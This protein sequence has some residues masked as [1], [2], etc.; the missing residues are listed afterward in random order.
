MENKYD[1]A[2]HTF[3][4]YQNFLVSIDNEVTSLIVAALFCIFN[5]L[6][7]AER[8]KMAKLTADHNWDLTYLDFVALEER[9]FT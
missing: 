8:R 2:R 4:R 9:F 5:D 6:L 3:L 1:I 7:L